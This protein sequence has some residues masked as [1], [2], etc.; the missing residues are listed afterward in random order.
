[1]TIT[2][3]GSP[4]DSTRKAKE[5][6]KEYQIP[7]VERNIHHNPF[8]VEEIQK[9]LALTVD[10][11]DEIIAKRSKIYKELNLDIDSLSLQELLNLIEKHPGLLRNPIILDDQRILVG[12]NENDIRK[13]LPR[14]VRKRQWLKFRMENLT[15]AEG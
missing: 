9:V 13:F 6:F 2:I 15:L 10:G 11:T 3:Y 7:F 4:C 5:W 12:F 8:T 14:K 1:M